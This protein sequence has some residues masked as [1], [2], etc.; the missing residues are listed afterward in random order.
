M[1][2]FFHRKR[3]IS[4]KASIMHSMVRMS[5]LFV[6]L[7]AIGLLTQPSAVQAQPA[8]ACDD[9]ANPIVA[10]NCQAGSG[11]WVIRQ[12]LGDIAG[13]AYPPS[14][15][16]GET[17]TLFVDTSAERYRIEIYRLGYYGGLGGRLV[18]T[19][20]DLSG[21]AQP[22]C[23]QEAQ[24]GLLS[25]SNWNVS[26]EL[27][28]PP[29]WVSGVYWAKLVR[30]D[31][32]GESYALF[33]VR[34]DERDAPILYQQ[35]LFTFHAYNNYGG[36]SL[37][38][39]NSTGCPTVATTPRAVAVSLQRPYSL[40]QITIGRSFN[41]VLHVEFPVFRW[42]EQQGYDL[43]YTT[44]LDVHRAGTEAAPNELLDHQVFLSV[45]H[46]EYWTHEMR[47]AVE[48]ARDQ[49]VN[50]G[51]FSSN[52]SYWR[53]RLEADPW[54][55]EPDSVV[56]TY[57]TTENGVNDPSGDLTSTFRDPERTAE[58]ENSLVGIQYIGDN[59]SLYFPLRV[60]AEQARDPLYR[61]TALQTMP[62][63][64]YIQ[65]GE[66]ILGWEW[67]AVTDN[68]NTPPGLEVLAAS[69]VYGLRLLDAGNFEAGTSQPSTAHL[70]RYTAESGALVMAFGT[71]QW[72][73][74]LGA[75]GMEPTEPDALIQQITVNALAD[76][77]VQPASPTA[78]V[79]LDGEDRIVPVA[80]E[81]FLRLDEQPTPDISH[82]Q[83]RPLS[84]DILLTGR[85][86]TVQWW[87]E[88]PSQGQLWLGEEA[89][90]TIEPLYTNTSYER[91]HQVTLGALV[92]THTYYLK[93]LAVAENGQL[94]E[95]AEQSFTTPGNLPFQV[96]RQVS[97][98][99]QSYSCWSRENPAGGALVIAV[100]LL[101]LVGLG[102]GLL[103]LLRRRRSESSN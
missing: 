84:G 33:V 14:I 30:P 102:I 40:D 26:Y 38:T 55:G 29:E 4:M 69:P 101:L 35:S 62:E 89:G 43:S 83:I 87:T 71:N 103:R 8:S 72:G 98:A 11:D 18:H 34:D 10:E 42:L 54:T 6:L 21:E 9:P 15:N 41:H 7:W 77:G 96:A 65:I 86:V 94:A 45:G 23:Q 13:Y 95:S 88:L 60:T 51:F 67:D 25:C 20:D 73:W 91:F 76:M 68:G 58:P 16:L 100:P 85:A 53:V 93:I 90:H 2:G 74:G 44:N 37:Y 97:R 99:G 32:G 56:I 24:T 3:M 79:V 49:G 75:R 5:L 31:T 50:L 70:T 48:A 1:R 52:V 19:V 66:D 46:D 36:K 61:H 64:T 57:K 47:D 22:D 27:S 63:N 39:V 80:E 78:D 81:R 59:D 17:V 92:P 28:V 12:P 82:V